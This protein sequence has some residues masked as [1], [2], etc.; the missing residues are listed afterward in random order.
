MQKFDIE[1]LLLVIIRNCKG[2]TRESWLPWTLLFVKLR[3]LILYG[4]SMKNIDMYF[5]QPTFMTF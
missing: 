4:L 1:Q 2:L 3:H 5:F